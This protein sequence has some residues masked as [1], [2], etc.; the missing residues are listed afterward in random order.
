MTFRTH[1]TLD[2][3]PRAALLRDGIRFSLRSK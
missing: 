2:G 3:A 1:T